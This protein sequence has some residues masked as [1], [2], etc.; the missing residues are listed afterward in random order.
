VSARAP[1]YA[2]LSVSLGVSLAMAALLLLVLMVRV[3]FG[4]FLVL[5]EPA[6][7]GAGPAAIGYWEPASL[8][9]AAPGERAR[10]ATRWRELL[11]EGAVLEPRGALPE[12]APGARVIVSDARFLDDAEAASLRAFVE[13][14]GGA[15]VA[16][17]IGV[18]AQENWAAGEVRMRALLGAPRLVSVPRDATLRVAAGRRGPLTAGLL[19][20][21]RAF[22]GWEPRA[23]AV[24][25]A[26]AELHWATYTLAPAAETAGASLRR[27]LGA[28]R[29]V[30]LGPTPEAAAFEPG[31]Q[32]TYRRF[33][34]NAL[35]WL[36]RGPA[37]EALAWPGG[38][39]F[40]GLLAMDTEY[41]FE[42]AVPVADLVERAKLP[43]TFV[44]LVEVAK[45]HPEIVGRLARLGEIGSHA[46]VHAGFAGQ[47]AQEQRARLERARDALLALGA[48]AVVGFRAPEESWDA[49]TQ[50]ALVATG[51]EYML[52]ERE[53]PSLAPRLVPV[54]GASL[55]HIPR[56]AA[57]DF[58]LVYKR[59]LEDAAALEREMS[60]DAAEAERSG[61]LYYFSLH[62]QLFGS[63][64]RLGVLE[65]V[66]ARLRERG[67]W[68]ARA[69][70]IAAWWRA[71]GACD[72]RFERAGPQRIDAHVTHRGPRAIEG[73]ALR[74]WLDAPA[75]TASA[76]SSVLFGAAPEVRF[77][78]GESRAD[79]LLPPVP[80][81]GS[82]T[83]HFEWEPASDARVARAR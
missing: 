12:S 11:P 1:W 61:G 15:L 35:A 23:P 44:T 80:A 57:D 32:A 43:F 29:L 58:D 3:L 73:L 53:P 59:K 34:G 49:T 68:L 46:D 66:A 63:P 18:R 75:R 16:G 71:R 10:R 74:V 25:H 2:S 6:P 56:G 40:A 17:W 51:H 31:G 38:A 7:V 33:V 67:A 81:G 70:E 76:A 20:A 83:W 14:G 54:D 72:V 8:A 45:L 5:A 50:L 69:D 30:W 62:T 78:P 28:G 77:V 9:A 27:E 60:L 79:L 82:R 41:Q 13:A 48:P 52:G 64:E 21:E 24:D 26:D 36:A 19:P 47:P 55:V 37:Y 4:P 65:R 39:P 22:L 42:N